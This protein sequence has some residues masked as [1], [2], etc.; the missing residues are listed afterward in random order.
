MS[1]RNYII[2]AVILVFSAIIIN[3]CNIPYLNPFLEELYHHMKNI[4]IAIPA[5]VCAIL[6]TRVGMY[7]L[8]IIM[9]GIIDV[10]YIAYSNNIAYTDY[11]ITLPMLFSFLII[12]FGINVIRAIFK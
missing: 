1:N 4:Y 11:S 8:L 7:W 6:L 3:F 2:F 12:V 10:A 9:C 5:V